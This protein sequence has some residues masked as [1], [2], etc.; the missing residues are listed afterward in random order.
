MTVSV[1]SLTYACMTTIEP[2]EVRIWRLNLDTSPDV[3]V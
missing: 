2:V 1:M 3:Q